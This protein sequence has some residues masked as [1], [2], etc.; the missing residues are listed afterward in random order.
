MRATTELSEKL[1]FR[2]LQEVP[3]SKF[4]PRYAANAAKIVYP[5]RNQGNQSSGL[6]SCGCCPIGPPEPELDYAT[7]FRDVEQRSSAF[8]TF[9]QWPVLR[10]FIAQMEQVSVF[11][12]GRFQTRGGVP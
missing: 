12:A 4:S 5:R 8:L 3:G 1:G 9:P 6:V 11:C 2:R 7:I 10:I